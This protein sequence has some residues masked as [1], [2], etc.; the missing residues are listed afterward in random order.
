MATSDAIQVAVIKV[1]GNPRVL[2]VCVVGTDA[3]SFLVA[4]SV[5]IVETDALRP[6][7]STVDDGRRPVALCYCPV[8]RVLQPPTSICEPVRYLNSS[9]N[10]LNHACAHLPAKTLD[11]NARELSDFVYKWLKT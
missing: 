2:V 1:C 6:V 10:A 11:N 9:I 8:H 7:Q 3:Q 5:S 4:D